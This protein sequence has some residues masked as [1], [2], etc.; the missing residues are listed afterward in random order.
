MNPKN[1]WL[2]VVAAGALFAFIFFFEQHFHHPDNGPRKLLPD[3]NAAD[4]TAVQVRPEGH[5]EMRAIRTNAAWQLA[6]PVTYPANSPAVENF[7]QA[8]Q[9][10]TVA[11]FISELD[12]KDNPDSDEAYG[13][14]PP[15]ISVVL[16]E[17]KSR[18]QIHFGHRTAPGDQVFVQVVGIAGISVVSADVLKFLPASATDWRETALADLARIPF[19]RVV[20]T[21]SGKNQPL[22][23]QRNSTNKLWRMTLPMKA[24]ADNTKVEGALQDLGNLLVQ[25]FVSDDPKAD[26]ESFGL[27]PP[28]FSIILA[29]GTNVSLQLDFGKSPTNDSRLLYARTR[30]QNS[31]VTVSTNMLGLW[32][33][34]YDV[35][36]DRHLVRLSGPLDAVEVHA[37][38]SFSLQ[39]QTN[40]TWRI[41][42]QNGAAF[43]GDAKM[44]VAVVE[45]FG[46]MQVADF[47]KDS[48]TELA[49]HDYGLAPPARQYVLKWSASTL[50]TNAPTELDFGTNHD[51][52]VFAR[53]VGEESV[54]GIA[55]SD[56]SKLPSVSWQLRDR[57]VWNF[58]ENDVAR[59]VI[60]QN[61]KTRE[62]VHTGTNDWALAPGSQG[63]I[64]DAAIEDT[65]HHLGNLTATA[66]AGRGEASLSRFGFATNG[67]H[68]TMQLKNGQKL[69][70]QFGG[71]TP[72]GSRY[73]SVVLDNEPW[74]FEFPADLDP[75]V[76]YCLTIPA[77]L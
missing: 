47:E 41:V 50:G 10:V 62:I 21:N 6:E 61:G 46:S 3:L 8:L 29:R 56:Y 9:H 65:V 35:F 73:A 32:R 20:V 33:A 22:E 25:H 44:A 43:P 58:S 11:T 15:Q 72:F 23:L 51:G 68:L 30:G 45:Q 13:V 27:Q 12:L 71:E 70:V 53:R 67:L 38:D 37:D 28:D 1:T 60:Q 52:K 7:L 63:V 16:Y 57:N 31:V 48:V 77:G 64:N 4:I 24:R 69:G 2:W 18:L 49:W 39:W 75:S 42:P 66:W 54:Y 17:G 55:P 26:L 74:I 5:Q 34:S 59:I 36:R 19:D 14:E 40:D 76:Q